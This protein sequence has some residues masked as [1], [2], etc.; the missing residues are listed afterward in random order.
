MR[1]RFSLGVPI[2][3]HPR[4]DLYIREKRTERP[5]MTI[6]DISP[7]REVRSAERPRNG[8]ANAT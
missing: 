6:F 5:R 1:V 8:D 4:G 2:P 3:P 7:R